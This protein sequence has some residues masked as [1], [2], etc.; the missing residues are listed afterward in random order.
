MNKNLIHLKNDLFSLKKSYII[1]LFLVLFFGIYKNIICLFNGGSNKALIM[2]KLLLIFLALLVGGIKDYLEEK[3]IN[4]GFDTIISLIVA[5]ILPF[6]TNPLIFIFS[7]SFLFLLDYIDKDNKLNRICIIKLSVIII[8]FLFSNYSYLTPAENMNEYA[9]SL[10]D[11]FLGNQVG[12]IFSTSVLLILIS[13][14][15]LSFNKIYKTNIALISC[16]A[17]IATSLIFLMTG[18]YMSVFTHLL[19]SSNIFAF[20]FIAP[21]SMYSPYKPK[22]VLIYGLSIGILA[23]II[24]YFILSEEGAIIAILLANILMVL[25]EKFHKTTNNG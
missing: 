15:I 10:F 5:M 7:L 24:S 19:N 6:N 21:F 2:S 18:N 12:G 22:E 25:K 9:Y 20:V 11:N 16:G 4:L 13:L 14:I 23:S 8:L 17:Y 3:K 1:C